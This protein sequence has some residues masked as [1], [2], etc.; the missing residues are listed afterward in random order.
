[1]L[2]QIHI[3]VLAQV[4]NRPI[5]VFPIESSKLNPFPAR[6]R[7]RDGW[8]HPVEGFYPQL[9]GLNNYRLCPPLLLGYMNGNFH[10]LVLPPRPIVG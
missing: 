7:R 8:K 10:A 5:I 6:D 3:L 4:L 2:F 9:P 1:M